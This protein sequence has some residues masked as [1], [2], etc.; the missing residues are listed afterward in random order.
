M[1]SILNP[2]TR[3]LK[4]KKIQNTGDCEDGGFNSGKLWKLKKKLAPRNSKPPSAME[5]SEG[6]VLTSDE[7]ILNE[8]VKHNKSVFKPQTI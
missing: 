5:D 7:D 8:A 1:K 2:C 4:K 6:N 3:K